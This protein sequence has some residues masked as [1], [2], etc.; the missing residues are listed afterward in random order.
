MW[1]RLTYKQFW[2]ERKTFWHFTYSFSMLQAENCVANNF[3][4]FFI[5]PS[6]W[7]QFPLS[8][9][10]FSCLYTNSSHFKTFQY[11]TVKS[12]VFHTHKSIKLITVQLSKVG[13][14]TIK[15][16]HSKNLTPWADATWTKNTRKCKLFAWVWSQ[17]MFKMST[18]CTDTCL[19]I[20]SSLVNC[21][22]DNVSRNV[23]LQMVLSFPR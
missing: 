4:F 9:Q 18:I 2:I 12:N 5:H 1:W 20:L 23:S 22:V 21:S 14:L 13:Q 19:E 17:K 16:Q 8:S 3:L 7:Q 11:K 15:Y 10:F 6:H